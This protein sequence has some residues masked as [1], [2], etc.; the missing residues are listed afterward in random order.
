MGF[1]LAPRPAAKIIASI[2]NSKN[3]YEID[4]DDINNWYLVK[5]DSDQD[6]GN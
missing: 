2:V 5:S 4:L 3:R 6:R 1:N